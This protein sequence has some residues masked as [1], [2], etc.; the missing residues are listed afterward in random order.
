MSADPRTDQAVLEVFAATY[1]EDETIS[2][3]L[4]TLIAAAD[5]LV[6]DLVAFDVGSLRDDASWRDADDLPPAPRTRELMAEGMSRLTA[7]HL[8][9]LE[10]AL[11]VARREVPGSVEM[12]AQHA[13][14]ALMWPE[15]RQLAARRYAGPDQRTA[16]S[17]L[18]A[19]VPPHARE[20]FDALANVEPR[21]PTA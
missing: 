9:V 15:V 6:A 5:A 7:D 2:Y 10:L 11:E 18:G 13:A 3:D 1:L 21:Q 14:I 17:R 20:P 8:C 16:W 19:C 4:G 12:V